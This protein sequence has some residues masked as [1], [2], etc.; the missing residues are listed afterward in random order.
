MPDDEKI[1]KMW[2]D[3]K[4]PATQSSYTSVIKKLAKFAEKPISEITPSDLFDFKWSMEDYAPNTLRLYLLAVKSFFRF[5]AQAG[6]VASDP[7]DQLAVPKVQ[8]RFEER[9]LTI[10]EVEQI[11]KAATKER[12]KLFIRFLYAT[13]ARVSEACAVQWSDLRVLDRPNRCAVRL[14]GKGDKERNVVIAGSVARDLLATLQEQGAGGNGHIF[15]S[16]RADR[17]DASTAWRIVHSAA[18]N[19]G[20]QKVSPHWFRHSH[21]SHA[22]QNGASL[23]VVRDALGHSTV[24]VTDRY[25]HGGKG[26]SSAEYL[27]DV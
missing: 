27:R 24:A 5:A 10:D 23:P 4:S 11:V 1:V 19:A 18:E 15:T 9:I 20:F 25:L 6:F 17:L 8:D 14:L 22:I 7:A 12:D 13:G 2:L 21:A 3:G 26:D 16:E